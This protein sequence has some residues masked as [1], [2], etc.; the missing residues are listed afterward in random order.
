[1]VE[2]SSKQTAF[3]LLPHKEVLYG[4]AA[5]GGKSIAILT[6]ASQ[7]L[8][9]PGYSALILRQTYKDLALP[10]ALMDVAYQWWGQTAAKWKSKTY[11]WEFPEGSTL[12]FGYME[13]EKDKYQYQGAQ[14]QFIGFD[15]L[16]QFETESRY[17]YLF[18]RLRRTKD[19][20]VPLRVRAA[21]NPGG[22]GHPWVKERFITHPGEKRLFIPAFLEDNPFLDQEEYEE[23]LAELD[24]V[25]REQLR[26][27]DWEID[28]RGGMFQRQWFD[29]IQEIPKDLGYTVRY[30]DMAASAE[31]EFNDPDW[32]VGTKMSLNSRGGYT[33]SDIVRFRGTPLENE[34]MV[35]ATAMA[36]GVDTHVFM[37]QE[38]GSSGK[39]LVSHYARNV[40][41]GWTFRGDK[42]YRKASKE[43]R[44]KPFS[45]AAEDGLVEI[46]V[47]SWIS[48]WLDEHIIFPDGGH[49][50]QV[51]SSVGAHAMIAKLE[52]GTT[53]THKAG[54]R[55]RR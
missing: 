18:S 7:Y 48:P 6:A 49:D 8:D 53:G 33:I 14:L 29:L 13:T 27:G 11:T 34:E 9:V 21:T 42:D 25:T 40:L 22:I 37:E 3:L 47:G 50:D 39:A 24:V 5:G 20:E 28:P 16:T 12:T 38:P 17:L 10:D 30:W 19:F 41:K 46:L 15:E 51:D 55:Y 2:P 44:A 54:Q 26:H 45:A 52:R 35:R 1:M 43:I 32:T 23:S 4:G 31:Q 36:D